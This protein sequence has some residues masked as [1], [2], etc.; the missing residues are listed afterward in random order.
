MTLDNEPQQVYL[1]AMTP[2]DLLS[3]AAARVADRQ[4]WYAP[5]EVNHAR[6]AAG[7]S[8]IFEG[9][10]T[11]E[12]VA[13]AMM[14]LKIARLVETPGHWDSLLDIVGYCLTYARCREVG[15]GFDIDDGLQQQMELTRQM[16][17]KRQEEARNGRLAKVATT[18]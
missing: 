14:W 13:L 7:W 9:E 16:W 5:P 15:D 6:I 3:Q 17:W 8:V 10:V 1:H 4:N 12:K 2:D 18:P 11:P